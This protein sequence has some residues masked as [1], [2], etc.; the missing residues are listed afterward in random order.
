MTVKEE[1]F[2]DCKNRYAEINRCRDGELIQELPSEDIEEI[3]RSGGCIMGTL[4]K[5]ICDKLVYNPFE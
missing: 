1:V 4:E 5:F 3:V 2:N